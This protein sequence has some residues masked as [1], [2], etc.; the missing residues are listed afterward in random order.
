MARKR[1]AC[2]ENKG[3]EVVGIIDEIISDYL[4]KGYASKLSTIDLEK[5]HPRTF[6]LPIFTVTNPKKPGK[7]RPV[8]DAA[9]NLKAPHF[10]RHY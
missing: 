3:A 10:I 2:V 4:T 7:I 6:Y 1:M 9:A 8:F 5:E